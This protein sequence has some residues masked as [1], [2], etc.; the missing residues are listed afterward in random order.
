[1]AIK[2]RLRLAILRR[3]AAHW[4]RPPEPPAGARPG[5]VLVI[6]PDHLGDILLTFPALR[7]LRQ[8][9]PEARITALVGP[10]AAPA[11]SL[12]PDVDAVETCPF[13]GFTRRTKG[14]PW[15]PYA[16]LRD[17]ARRLRSQN[18][19]A[20]LILRPD[21][22]W[23]AMLAR[24]AGIPIRTGYDVP[25]C[26]PFLSQAL[27]LQHD[28]HHVE[29]SLNLVRALAGDAAAS[30]R[31]ELFYPVSAEDARF[32][33]EMD[34]CWPGD[35]PLVVVHPGS[36]APV[37]LWTPQGFAAVADGLTERRQARVVVTGGPGEEALVRAVAHSCIHN[38]YILMGVSLGRMAALLSRARL[39]VGLDSGIMHLAVAVGTPSVHLYGPV[40]RTAFGPWGLA[41]RHA[42]ITSDLPC[43]PCNRLDYPPRELSK[44]PCVRDIP[45]S[46]VLEAAERLLGASPQGRPGTERGAL[47]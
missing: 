17:E 36:G 6:R 35:G 31:P 1:M 13:P 41:E 24:L 5:K 7:L 19:D 23:G 18:F 16:L 46:K 29:H 2:E 9:L 44:H 25:E 28:R 15:A 10:W 30:F 32:A 34:S 45:A 8:S 37:K 14:S 47:V 43:I 42:V 39:A 21:H 12:N 26:L 40:A 27:P 22:W 20:A 33:A 11:I 38:P 3:M 4:P